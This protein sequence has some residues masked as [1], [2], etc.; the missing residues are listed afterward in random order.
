MTN[1]ERLPAI[2]RESISVT[3]EILREMIGA[4]AELQAI[5]KSNARLLALLERSVFTRDERVRIGSL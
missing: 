2:E 4:R 3:Q 5:A 1:P